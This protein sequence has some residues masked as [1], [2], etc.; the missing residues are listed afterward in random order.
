MIFR[1]RYL[2]TGGNGFIG[3]SLCAY[4]V[5][6]GYAVTGAVRSS[7]ELPAGVDSVVVGMVDGRTDWTEALRGVDVLVHLAARVHVPRE[8]AEYSLKEF[9]KVNVAGTNNLARFAAANAV[10]RF[11]YVSSIGVNG[12]QTEA[13]CTF[14]ETD[15]PNPNSAYAL[16]KWEAEQCLLRVADETGMG[17]V[18]VRPPLVYGYGAPGNFG[19]LVRAVQGGWP[20]PLGA[21]HNLRS[22]VALDNLVDFIVTCMS[23]PKAVNQTFLVS[24]GHDLSTTELVSGLAR[25]SEVPQRLVPVPQWVLRAGAALLDK[26]HVAQ[27]LCSNLQLDISKARHVLGWQPSISIDEG[28]RRVVVP[29]RRL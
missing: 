24:D 20:L 11:V 1:M 28:L 3:R 9:R 25:A 4:L 22:F 12:T 2:I 23:H 17:V 13:G 15:N 7:C 26:S 8:K 21:V 29:T 5:C 10:K 16:S 18:I 19:W 6:G 14:S 27:R